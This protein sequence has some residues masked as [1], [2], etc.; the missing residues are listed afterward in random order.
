MSSPA[1]TSSLVEYVKDSIW[2]KRYPVSY[3]GLD[4]SA[5][6]TLIRL[7]GGGL[8]VHSPSPIDDELIRQIEPLGRVEHILAPGNFHYFYV[9][10]WQEFYPEATTWI[11]PGVERKRP[12]LHFDWLLGDRS[13]AAWEG[14]ID[15]VL[16]R[17]TRFIWEVAF[18]HR[19]S[20]T[21]VLTDL[22]ENIG[23][24]TPGAEG[25]MLKLWWKAVFQMWNRPKPA[26][27]YQFGWRDKG[28]ARECLERILGWDF[29]RVVI[30]HGD[31]IEEDAHARLREAW[32]SPLVG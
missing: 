2:L 10:D 13:P 17:G 9:S 21:L 22:I 29:E 4:F 15:Q 12:E 6:T 19:A 3:A 14:E 20:R 11:C 30:A 5:R 32:A 28:A 23:D 31:C 1:L 26:P 27:E 7:A 16:V 18:L 8:L 25:F 24:A